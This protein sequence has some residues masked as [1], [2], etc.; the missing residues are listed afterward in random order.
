M[1]DAADLPGPGLSHIFLTPGQLSN[2]PAQELRP[3]PHQGLES[4]HP[5][6]TTLIEATFL[7]FYPRKTDTSGLTGKLAAAP[8]GLALAVS[9]PRPLCYSRRGWHTA[10]SPQWWAPAV[11]HKTIS[12]SAWHGMSSPPNPS[13]SCISRESGFSCSAPSRNSTT[14]PLKKQL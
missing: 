1:A 7:S 10:C 8:S 14:F 3:S 4:T 13:P 12:P 2:V 9:T 5:S 11:C 6:K